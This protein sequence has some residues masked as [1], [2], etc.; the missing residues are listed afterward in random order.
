MSSHSMIPAFACEVGAALPRQAETVKYHLSVPIITFRKIVS[1][2]SL[3]LETTCLQSGQT[4]YVQPLP[5]TSVTADERHPDQ[6]RVA[7]DVTKRRVPGT[8]Q[9]RTDVDHQDA[10]GSER[11]RSRRPYHEVV[12]ATARSLRNGYFGTVRLS[13]SPT[14]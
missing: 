7:D 3:L 6:I 12:L 8:G 1:C 5:E 2:H 4:D 13:P 14:H 9:R 10:G 11:R